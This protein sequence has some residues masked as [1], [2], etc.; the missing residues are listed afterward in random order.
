MSDVTIVYCRPC[1]YEKRAKEA[2]A[3]LRRQLAL[4][5]DLVAGKGGVFQVKL[6]DRI[7]ASRS[8]G[9]FPGTD[10]IVAA[11]TAARH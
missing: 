4:E 2:A 7:V 3:A 5:A 11:V 10:E 9:H 8:K 6:G 1:G